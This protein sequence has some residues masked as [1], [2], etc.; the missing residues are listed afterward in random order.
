MIKSICH[1]HIEIKRLLGAAKRY[2]PSS[3]VALAICPCG[4]DNAIIFDHQM[5]LRSEKRLELPSKFGLTGQRS[6][7]HTRA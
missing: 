5:N 1:W 6:I 3:K 7:S 4:Y 2:A